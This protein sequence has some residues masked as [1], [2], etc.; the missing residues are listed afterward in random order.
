MLDVLIYVA[1]PLAVVIVGMLAVAARRPDTFS[2]TRA[3]RIAAPPESIYP[4]IADLRAMNT[5]NP[6][7]D[8]DPNIEIT[9]SGPPQGVGAAHTWRGNRNVGEGSIEIVEAAPPSR[10]VM[11]L[12]MVKPMKAD[13]R[14]VFTLAPAGPA[15]DVTWT[16]SGRQPLLG[17]LMTMFIDCDSMVGRQF[18]KGL[19]A[20][21]TKIEATS[22]AA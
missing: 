15:T 3:I 21:K 19:A 18:E 8:P 9:Y 5:W 2:T 14:V 17:K 10:I 13:N 6:F 20:L 16:M 11:R 22:I 1:M 12:Q 4:M 7:V